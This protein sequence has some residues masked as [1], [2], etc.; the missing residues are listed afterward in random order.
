MQH[1]DKEQYMIKAPIRSLYK[2]AT[3]CCWLLVAS[4]ALAAC[5]SSERPVAGSSNPAVAAIDAFV[6]DSTDPGVAAIVRKN[7]ETLFA[8]V[9]GKRHIDAQAPINPDTL[10]CVGSVSKQFTAFG[11]QLL[12]AEG[13][14]SSDDDVRAMIP[15]VAHYSD[16]IYVKDL[17]YHSS[18]IRDVWFSFP[19]IGLNETDSLEQDHIMRMIGRYKALDFKPG[20]RWTYSN[21]AYAVL[22]EVI[23][24]AAGEPFGDFMEERVFEPLG[25][26]R[27][28]YRTKV[29]NEWANAATPYSK[30]P[31]NTHIDPRGT[32]RR[33]PFGYAS[34]GTSGL[35]TTIN[36]FGKWLDNY[37][38][39]IPEHEK[40]VAAMF[41]P[42]KLRNG[43]SYSYTSGL[44]SNKLA[45]QSAFRHSGHDQEFVSRMAY[46]P[47]EKGGIFVTTNRGEDVV[48]ILKAL[49]A[50]Y[51]PTEGPNPQP[52]E[53]APLVGDVDLTAIGQY[54]SADGVGFSIQKGQKGLELVSP[55][56]GAPIAF[57]T[58]D[59]Y[60]LGGS[61]L[62]NGSLVR[63]SDGNITGI[64]QPYT[65]S[66]FSGPVSYEKQNSSFQ[67]MSEAAI[68]KGDFEGRYYSAELDAFLTVASDRDGLTIG[69]F[70]T[71]KPV[72]LIPF[73]PNMFQVYWPSSAYREEYTLIFEND[74]NGGVQRFKISSY[75]VFNTNFERVMDAAMAGVQY[76]QAMP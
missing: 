13:K 29:S 60:S 23:E 38:K 10:F 25:M 19:L 65:N 63:D 35:W 67:P 3:Y 50:E 64:L 58:D 48:D 8:E 70:R 1:S 76:K 73:G 52:D 42:G 61:K 74:K 21:S 36:D 59:T 39:P 49:A 12:I 57:R 41:E 40:A 9:R 28:R 14:L 27:T 11:A 22:A 34:Y 31:F 45:G 33:V 75:G 62:P 4:T 32:W 44:V 53:V 51:F 37:A 66:G 55:S 16:P 20:S 72:P 69:N 17:I 15:E 7:G 30:D 6:G 68:A 18:G 24:K 43:E 46:F 5:S 71:L 47:T 26:S 56:G 54:L 2:L